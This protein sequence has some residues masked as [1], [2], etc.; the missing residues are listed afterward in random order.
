MRLG[1]F[2]T[3]VVAASILN[4]FIAKAQAPP[5]PG[6]RGESRNRFGYDT[7]P[8]FLAFD[9]EYRR[10]HHAAHEALRRLQ[11]ELARQAG[12]GRA[13][14]CARQIFLEARWL[15]YYS[16]D[17]GRIEGRLEALREMLARVA[18]PPDAREQVQAD[19]SYDHCS[20]S[21]FL[22]LDSTIEEIEDR[23]SRGERPKFPLR[24]LDRINSPEK[25]RSYLD[26][27]LISDVRHTGLDNRFELN[28]AI[29]ALIRLITGDLGPIYPFHPQ[30]R[31][32]LFDYLDNR[33]QD[34][35]TGYYGGWYQRSD[36]TIRK[37]ADL[38]I[39]FH[40][41]SYRR[42]GSARI[43]EM[44]ATTLACK[45]EEYPFGWREERRPSNHHHYDVVRLFR[46]GW[47]RMDEAQRD[48]ARAAMREMLDFCLNESMNTDGSFK[49]LDEDTL[50]SSFLFPVSLLDEL[51]YFRWTMRFW[52]WDSYPGSLKV[53]QRI[54]RKIQSLGLTDPESRK[55]L[56]RLRWAQWESRFR[57][58]V[59]AVLI[60]A[61]LAGWWLRRRRRR[62][63]A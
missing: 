33:W 24:L 46:I 49:L 1:Y 31:A 18:D 27:L 16:A 34:P 53:A 54:E 22:K 61:P 52:T 38:S 59:T 29:S 58:G 40:I 8:D 28:I 37:T 63:R 15:V 44:M 50:G 35:K 12:Q 42:K 5:D 62:L 55:A 23:A 26:S 51:G 45:D 41:V 11:L 57:K 39:T 30:L 56:R 7:A 4:V 2:A 6:A 3:I 60:V 9:P 43:R 19:G 25:L 47:P 13:T 20:Q 14:P 21:W 17:W 48:Q 32:A 10:K 36:G